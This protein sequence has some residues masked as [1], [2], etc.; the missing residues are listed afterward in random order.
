MEVVMRFF[1]LFLR[2]AG[3]DRATALGRRRGTSRLTVICPRDE[4]GAL[5]KQICLDFSAAGPV[6]YTHLTLPTKRIV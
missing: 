6:S 1:D 2:R 3:V 4:L 5:R